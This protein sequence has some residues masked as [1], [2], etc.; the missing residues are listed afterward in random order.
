MNIR[1]FPHQSSTFVVI[2][3]LLASFVLSSCQEEGCTDP[4]A[5]NF[6]PSAKKDDGNC[7]YEANTNSNN[8]NNNDNN[9]NNND[10][11]NTISSDTITSDINTKAT[12]A[13]NT[14]ICG[15]ID[16]NAGLTINPGVTLTMCA[17]SELRVRENG[18]LNASGT[19]SNPIAILGE[20]NTPGYWTV[21]EFNA[22]NPNNVLKH[23]EI[24]NGGSSSFWNNAMV[25]VNDNNN[26]QVSIENVTFRGSKGHGLYLEEGVQIPSFANNS[27]KN[28]GAEG[29]RI[30]TDLIYILD[31]QTDYNDGNSNPYILI[32][33]GDPLTNNQTWSATTEPYLIDGRLDISADVTIEPGTNIRMGNSAEIRVKGNGSLNAE[34]TAGNK[35]TFKGE[36]ETGGFWEVIEINS[37]NPNNVFRY[38]EIFHGGSES[39]W[40]YTSLW[41]NDNNNATLDIQNCT[42]SKSGGWGM[43]VENGANPTPSDKATM[44]SQNTFT[45]NGKL[46]SANCTGDCSVDFR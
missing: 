41:L 45:D 31:S 34:G 6:D 30:T 20:V 17:G 2:L 46:N 44:T 7:F 10:N 29:L 37:N 28:N 26:S 19:S 15:N 38:V 33:S 43:T 36:T 4:N 35:I 18:Y 25:W 14:Y 5:L 32:S 21:L 42:I 12:I 22:N 39:F 27:F 1:I 9:D 24:A 8:N 40:D 16:I 3:L 11:D 23:V 13:N